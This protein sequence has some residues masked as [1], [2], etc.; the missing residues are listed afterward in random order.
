MLTR[1]LPNNL[2]DAL[3][4]GKFVELY[5]QKH[6]QIFKHAPR[7]KISDDSPLNHANAALT[8]EK[9]LISACCLSSISPRMPKT[10]V[11][12]AV[13]AVTTAA[14]AAVTTVTAAATTAAVSPTA[15]GPS[16]GGW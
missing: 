14:V 1:L 13:A 10:A 4:W 16:G 2:I 5:R 11:T 8:Q 12:A 9:I 15:A 7:N 3:V 6:R